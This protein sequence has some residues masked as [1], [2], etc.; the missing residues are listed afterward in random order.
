MGGST[1]STWRSPEG[2]PFLSMSRVGLPVSVDASSAGFRIVAEQH[3]MI[4]LEP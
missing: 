1:S 3:T 2:A 4:G